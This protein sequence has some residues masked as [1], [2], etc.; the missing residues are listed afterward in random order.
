MRQVSVDR[1]WLRSLLDRNPLKLQ[2]EHRVPVFANQW[3]IKRSV[4][5]SHGRLTY[6]RDVAS[7]FVDSR[8]HSALWIW[9]SYR[10][11]RWGFELV[12]EDTRR[13]TRGNTRRNTRDTRRRKGLM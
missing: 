4:P 11:D 2:R 9:R 1:N 6:A 10:K 12:H 8:V 3:G 13:E 7:L 5:D